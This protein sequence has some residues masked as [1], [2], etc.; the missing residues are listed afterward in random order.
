MNNCFLQPKVGI[1]GG[2]GPMAGA[3]L[4]QKIIQICRAKYGCR[5]DA[6]FPYIMLLN[7]PFGDMLEN[8]HCTKTLIQQQLNDCFL[9]LKNNEIELAVIACNTLHEFLDSKEGVPLVHLIE[10]TGV[11]IQKRGIDKTLVLCTTTSAQCKIHRKYFD[12]SYPENSAQKKI[13][14]LIY[15]I[16][17][18]SQCREDAHMLVDLLNTEDASRNSGKKM[19]LVLG[20]TEFSVFNEQFPLKLY[21]L[22]ER[23]AVFDPNQIAAERICESIFSRRTS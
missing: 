16:L 19:A 22:S 11:S 8:P 14:E 20:C 18:G 6:D 12:C 5:N 23:F 21:G 17:S 15:K 4:F 7:Y 3:Q 13:Q 9:Q 1:I 10:E 2:A